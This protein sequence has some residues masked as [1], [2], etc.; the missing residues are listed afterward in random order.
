MQVDT[1]EFRAIRDKVAAL[2]AEVTDLRR[3]AVWTTALGDAIES[4]GYERGRASILGGTSGR[5]ARTP[6]AERWL[7][8]VRD[9]E[10]ELQAGA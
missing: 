4:R 10:P 1:S 8:A 7:H 6:E 5:P 2:E 3:A 9:P